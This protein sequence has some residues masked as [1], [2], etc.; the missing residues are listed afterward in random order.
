MTYKEAQAK[1]TGRCKERRKLQNNTYLERRDGDAIA[2][3]LHATDVVT[4]FPDGT[5]EL[6]SGGWNTLTTRDRINNYL[7]GNWHVSS[8]RDTMILW[9]WK[10]GAYNPRG[11]QEEYLF[12]DGIRISPRGKVTGTGDLETHREA[13][14]QEDNER[15]RP[16]ARARYWVRKAQESKPAKSLTVPGILEEENVTV[17][18]A[19][20]KIYGLERFLLE[21][22]AKAIDQQAGYALLSL[23]LDRWQ[24][25]RA[26]KMTCPSTGAVYI[27]PVPPNLTTVPEALDWYFDCENYLGQVAQQA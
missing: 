3:I 12:V 17:R 16:R 24:D 4:L 20:M 2:V 1:L 10:G 22:G 27:S 8:E 11:E 13:Q 7:P 23:G 15:A 18:V 25:M 21:S 9:R 14:R 19:K 26:L 5:V 6:N